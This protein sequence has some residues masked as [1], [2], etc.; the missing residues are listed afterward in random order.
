MIST[1]RHRADVSDNDRCTA[2]GLMPYVLVL[3]TLAAMS[4]IGKELS[5]PL[6]NGSPTVTVNC[7]RAYRTATG[8]SP[9]ELHAQ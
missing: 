3:Q 8:I 7:P 4:C 2:T 6:R 9:A 5:R 1:V